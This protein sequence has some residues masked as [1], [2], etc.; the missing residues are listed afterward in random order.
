MPVISNLLF[1][2]VICKCCYSKY[3]P[4][5]RQR[6]QSLLPSNNLS[7]AGRV[8]GRPTQKFQEVTTVSN[9]YISTTDTD[10]QKLW[11]LWYP[12]N[13]NLSNVAGLKATRKSK[14]TT[15]IVLQRDEQAPNKKENG[16]VDIHL[17][18]WKW[19]EVGVF[20]TFAIFVF[21]VGYAKVVFHHTHF[22]EAYFPESFLML[23]LGAAVG[24][25]LYVLG[26]RMPADP[27]PKPQQ[28]EA[29][30]D[31]EDSTFSFPNFSPR[32]YFLVLLPP[33]ILEQSY[34]LYDSEFA[35]SLYPI[36]LFS[37]VGKLI[38]T[39]SIGAILHVLSI[40]KVFGSLPSM[41]NASPLLSW[42]DG[43]IFASIISAVD[44]VP[45]LGLLHEAGVNKPLYFLIFGESLLNDAVSVALHS[46]VVVFAGPVKVEESN[47]GMAVLAFVVNSLGGLAIGVIFGL[48]SAL[49]TRTTAHHRIVEP[50]TLLGL[51]YIAYLLAEVVHF[52]GHICLIGCGLLQAHYAFQNISFTSYVSIIHFVKMLSSTSDA[53]ILMFLGMTMVS[54]AHVWHT[55]FVLSTLILCFL[56][57][58]FGVYFLAIIHNSTSSNWINFRDQTVLAYCGLRGALCLCLAHMLNESRVQLKALFETTTLVVILFTTLFQGGTIKLLLSCLRIKR[59]HYREE[60]L[61]ELIADS[62]FSSVK[63]GVEEIAK[64]NRY[65]VVRRVLSRFDEKYMKKIFLSVN[66]DHEVQKA[67]HNTL[68]L[69]GPISSRAPSGRSLY[70]RYKTVAVINRKFYQIEQPWVQ[71]RRMDIHRPF[72][73][74]KKDKTQMKGREL[75]IQMVHAH[76]E[77]DRPLVIELHDV[78]PP[79]Y[80]NEEKKLFIAQVRKSSAQERLKEVI[81]ERTQ[82]ID[83]PPVKEAFQEKRP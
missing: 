74:E 13:V 26:Y 24:F 39:L 23:V 10:Q 63:E 77:V 5:Q 76:N 21:A 54:F 52:S 11:E 4:N 80:S 38:T 65:G 58:V 27:P 16:K 41:K 60:S 18:D 31:D 49:A 68:G 57:R 22:L 7:F 66:F 32:L 12:D 6:N 29:S 42:T 56:C 46:S 51:A 20:I 73:V 71:R 1:L 78:I 83:L 14:R 28:L 25:V 15:N 59:Q 67:M 75:D 34:A 2:L 64:T 70:S 36:L 50:L 47:Y 62:V 35:E 40:Y 53:V 61:S 17:V 48:I 33:I 45:V 8:A 81:F 3:L 9:K 37:I 30:S 44:P 79:I 82:K 69:E 19:H 72:R 43:L 55:G